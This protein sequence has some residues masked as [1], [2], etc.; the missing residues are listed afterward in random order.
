MKLLK[1]SFLLLTTA[2]CISSCMDCIKGDGNIVTID[3]TSEITEFNEI[4]LNG[5]YSMEITQDSAFSILLDGDENILHAITTKVV[6]GKLIVESRSGKCFSSGSTI[7]IR[8]SL[9]NLSYVELNGSGNINCDS[10]RAEKL[11]VLIAGSGNFRFS[12]LN[13]QSLDAKITGSGNLNFSGKANETNYRIDGS[14]NI[15]S[16]NLEQN[17]SVVEING[18]GNVYVSFL[19]SLTGVINGSG[20]VFYKTT[21][22]QINI[23]VNGSGKVSNSN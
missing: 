13:T 22:G 2:L 14:G 19:E 11:S 9:P 1:S 10:L 5:S 6:D 15:R 21:T 17:N 23:T 12:K 18:S 8:V 7:L 4:E 20:N 16:F 3:R